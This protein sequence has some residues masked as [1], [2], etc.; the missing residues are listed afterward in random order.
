MWK[1]TVGLH[2]CSLAGIHLFG[3]NYRIWRDEMSWWFFCLRMTVFHATLKM[4]HQ[5]LETGRRLI[6]RGLRINR[7]NELWRFEVE[8]LRNQNDNPVHMPAFSGQQI[9]RHM[10]RQNSG[11]VGK[12]KK[13]QDHTFWSQQ[14]RTMVRPSTLFTK[15]KCCPE[16]AVWPK[17]INSQI[18]VGDVITQK[19]LIWNNHIQGSENIS[20]N[21][22]WD[23]LAMW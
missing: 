5:H 3:R 16:E 12:V 20:D 21:A 1:A 22:G 23:G 2:Q 18:D 10:N 15:Q 6:K 11:K 9:K 17:N 4:H 19:N 13:L 14:Y 8:W 7:R